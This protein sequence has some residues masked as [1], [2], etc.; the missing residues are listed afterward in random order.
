M[1][2]SIAVDP[3]PQSSLTIHSTPST[4]WDRQLHLKEAEVGTMVEPEDLLTTETSPEGAKET[5]VREEPPVES[6][7]KDTVE[8]SSSV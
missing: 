1:V 6:P 8:N 5:R 2:Q 4:G 7:D 3:S